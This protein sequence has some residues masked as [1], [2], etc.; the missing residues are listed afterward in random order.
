MTHEKQKTVIVIGAG[1]G[2]LS[3]AISLATKGFRVTVFEKNKHVGGKLNLYE[4]D[5]F[6]FDM[7]PSIFT[8]PQYFKRLWER[9]GKRM[10][11][12]V[13]LQAVTP[14]WRNF[15]EDG[16][17]FDLC[18]DPQEMKA[19][20]EKIG[21]QKLS[22]QFV[23]FLTYAEEQYDML[24]RGYFEA[25]LDTKNDF[26]DFYDWKSLLKMDY[27]RS[28]HGRLTTYFKNPYIINVME[29]FIKYIG[30][31]ALRAPGYMNLLPVIQFRY[32]LWYVKDG[33]FNLAIGLKKLATSLGVEFH[34]NTEVVG[35]EKEN[36]RVSGV[37]TDDNTLHNADIVVSNMEVIPAYER[38]LDEDADFL[39]TLKPFEPACSGLVLHLATD[40][41]YPQLAH[42][43]FF[44]ARNQKKHFKSVFEKGC[45]P[46]D[47]HAVRCG[48]IAY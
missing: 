36:N 22:K 21:D 8:L 37:R 27:W 48:S 18:M 6:R 9:A 34:L 3:A 16:T 31:S 41:E 10:E 5:G 1:L 11:D 24:E 23:R 46:D 19:E 4:K 2:G 33:M 25:G 39:K 44:Y 15:F 26:A 43:N 20:L 29:Y 12:D 7:G 45:I 35:I 42:H 32:D 13:T 17:R 28:M 30:S 38:L 40:C 14:H 47:P